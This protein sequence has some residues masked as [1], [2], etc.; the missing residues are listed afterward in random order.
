MRTVRCHCGAE[1]TSPGGFL[2]NESEATGF[3]PVVDFDGGVRW[4]CPEHTRQVAAACGGDAGYLLP[5]MLRK[6][7]WT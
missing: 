2:K 3:Y 5:P 6:M 1:A 4:F 7:A